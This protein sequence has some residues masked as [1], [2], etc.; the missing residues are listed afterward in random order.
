MDCVA[1]WLVVCLV[2]HKLDI[3]CS[4]RHLVTCLYSVHSNNVHCSNPHYLHIVLSTANTVLWHTLLLV[5]WSAC[6]SVVDNTSYVRHHHNTF[7]LQNTF[8]S[9]L[10]PHLKHRNNNTSR[11]LF[12]HQYLAQSQSQSQPQPQSSSQ[13]QSQLHKLLFLLQTINHT[14]NTTSSMIGLQGLH[15]HHH[16]HQHKHQH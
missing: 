9:Q 7:P 2:K 16:H 1:S 10:K 12:T 13:S 11:L 6:T 8:R 14:A 5:D 3:R 15:Q 4:S